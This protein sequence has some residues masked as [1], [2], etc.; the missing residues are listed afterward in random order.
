MKLAVP[1][2]LSLLIAP[3]SAIA[4]DA[5]SRPPNIVLI[6][7]DDL[8]WKDVGYNCTDFYETPNLDR[9]AKQGMVF[10]RAYAAAGNCAPSR[11]CMLSGQY[12]PRHHVY[13][14]DSTDRGPKNLMRMVPVPN[15][16]GLAPSQVTM[17]EALKAAGYATG[18]FGKW[19]LG[20]PDGA[21][22]ASQGFDAATDPGTKARGKNTDDPKGVFTLTK[23]AGE[24]MEKNRDKPF[25]CYVPHHGIHSPLE[26][27]AATLERFQ[28]KAAGKQHSNPLYAACLYDFDDAVGQLLKKIADLGLEQ[29]TLVVFTS[30]NGGTQQSSQEPLRGNKGCYY[31][32]GIREPMIVRWPGVTKAGSTSDVPVINID[33]YP[34]FLEAAGAKPPEG[35]L[36]DGT[37]LLPLLKGGD[38][39]S[40]QA[41]F[42][43]FP[44][45]LDS[46]VI[47]GRDPVFRTRPVSAMT[48]G[49]WKLLLYHEEW[50]LDGGADKI[51]TH[52]AVELYNLIEDP[53]ERTNLAASNPAKRD[54]L[55]AAMLAWMKQTDALLP[56]QKNPA[57]DPSAKP[58]GAR[59]GKKAAKDASD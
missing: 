56:T 2:F 26:A 37:S 17:A 33:F 27:R 41:I 53:G 20:G 1:A 58:E 52:N 9:F 51:A 15:K 18:I 29:N 35:K 32:G 46:P 5:P 49:P 22:P 43:H 55:V 14:V 13:A 47:R 12:T 4:A 19:H 10:N 44:G 28:K 57:Y 25:F 30:D 11:A 54:E 59:R 6:F 45:Y 34:T 16:S 31:E 50:Q 7:A 48:T 42:W 38:K 39:L 40:R 8:G 36:L 21:P 23:L 24:F 3:L